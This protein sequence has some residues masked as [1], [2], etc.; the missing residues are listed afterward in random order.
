LATTADSIFSP[1]ETGFQ[2]DGFVAQFTFYR[3]ML[4]K[5]GVEPEIFRV[6][7]YKSAVEPFTNTSSSRLRAVNRR[8]KYLMLLRPHL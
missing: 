1:P 3:D 7:E 6:G 4:E 5:I 8:G 2:F